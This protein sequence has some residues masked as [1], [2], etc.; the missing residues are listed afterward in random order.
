MPTPTPSTKIGS[1]NF[2]GITKIYN[3]K[4][5]PTVVPDLGDYLLSTSA[6]YGYVQTG[7]PGGGGTAGYGNIAVL[8]F[9]TG[10]VLPATN[11]NGPYGNVYA[12]GFDKNTQVT[13]HYNNT[14]GNGVTNNTFAA[15]FGGNVLG[16][17]V[18]YCVFGSNCTANSLGA[19]CSFNTFGNNC[20]SNQLSPQITS[21]KLDDGCVG[22]KLSGATANVEL[23]A[24]C[25]G[26]EVVACT[27]TSSAPFLIPAGSKNVRYVNNVLVGAAVSYVLPKASTGALGGVIVGTGLSIDVNGLL[28]TVNTGPNFSAPGP[29]FSY[30]AATGVLTTTYAPENVANKVTNLTAPSDVTYPTTNAVV[31]ANTAVLTAANAYTD[32]STTSPLNFAGKY[33]AA[34][35]PG[36]PT[37]GTGASGAIRR[38]DLYIVTGANAD[39]SSTVGGVG[40]VNGDAVVALQAAPAQVTTNWTFLQANVYQATETAPGTARLALA[41]DVQSE[42]T[43]NDTR[44][45]TPKKLWLGL[46]RLLGMANVW[47]LKQT[48]T[49]APTFSSATPSTFLRVDANG[50]LVSATAADLAAVG[51][52]IKNVSYTG[53]TTFTQVLTTAHFPIVTVYDETRT[54]MLP[55]VSIAADFLSFTVDFAGTASTGTISYN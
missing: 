43:T 34:T 31:V 12:I 44:I 51:G 13:P 36:F 7:T 15:G 54:Q 3:F 1:L 45:V 32:Q 6:V 4:V 20:V 23:G 50:N 10:N 49:T 47:V 30:N 40:V 46:Y 2:Q 48:F 11:V 26:V 27:G 37:T 28:T 22:N 52:Q 53:V 24:G 33:S 35:N 21:C 9:G 42:V 41:A 16:L 29:F 17:G 19:N 38:G 14:Y 8:P 18:N 5:G 39:G 55:V 25:I